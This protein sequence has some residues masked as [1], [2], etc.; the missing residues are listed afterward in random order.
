MIA[1]FSQYFMPDT[2]RLTARRYDLDWLRVLAF[3]LLIFYHVGM[4]Y[5]Q[6]WGYHVK[7]QYLSQSLENLML[8]VNP[9]RMLILWFISGAAIRFILAKVNLG[10]FIV[11]RS[12]RLLLPLLFGILVVIPPQLFYEMTANGDLDIGYWQFYQ[13]FFDS[14]NPIFEKY[15]AGI[16][17][18]VDVNHLWYLRELWVFSLYLV[19][20]LP[21][22]NAS[23]F[24]KIIDHFE[25]LHGI[26]QMVVALTPIAL[27]QFLLDGSREVLGFLMIVYGYIFAWRTELWQKLADN[28]IGLLVAALI[29]YLMFALFYN[30]VWLKTGKES[31][32]EI[33]IL[34]YLI[35][36]FD[37]LVWLLAILG[38]SYK[39]LNR[40]GQRLTYFSDAVYPYYILHQTF[41]IAIGYELTQLNLGGVIEPVL[42]LV[43]TFALCVISFELIKRVEFLRPLFGLKLQHSYQKPWQYIGKAVAVM[44]IV[45]IGLEILI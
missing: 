39:F 4:L 3:G 26:L 34:G 1:K 33:L 9:W 19:A 6:N 17:P 29:T 40:T 5:V 36:S 41:I 35:Y 22:L 24:E 27:V 2:A 42:V 31:A 44:L 32:P 28:A 7:S 21:I 10:H 30:M 16:W 43:F 38:L 25:K 23:W 18:H 11:M 12:Y 15:Q 8:L 20:L 13:A 45:P 14:N 37:R